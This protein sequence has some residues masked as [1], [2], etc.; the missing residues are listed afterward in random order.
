MSTDPSGIQWD[1]GSPAVG[2]RTLTRDDIGVVFQ[3]IVDVTNGR[4]FAHEALVRCKRPEYCSPPVLFEHAVR[5]GQCGPLGRLIRDVA[6]ATCGSAPLFVNVHPSELTSK[7]LVQADEP[8]G[9]HTAPVFVEVTE[10]AAMLHFDLCLG[11]IRELAKRSGAQLVIDDFGVGYSSLDR[12]AD[13][14][15]ALI[16][17]DMSLVKGIDKHKRRQVVV[18]HIVNMCSELEVLVVAE[19]I[20]TLDE[21]CCVRDLGVSY[22]QGF[23]LARPATPPPGHDWPMR[24]LLEPS[25]RHRPPRE[26]RRDPRAEPPSVPALHAW[27]DS[28]PA[29][30]VPAGGAVSS[31]AGRRPRG[32][33]SAEMTEMNG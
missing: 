27:C 20:E 22:L 24:A 19:G 32:E 8:I 21:L 7:W 28:T 14:E 29:S 5:E 3:P 30:G 23:L 1:A 33:W 31:V 12:L 13:L 17:L 26:V 4:M 15:P 18:R 16:K 25:T 9:F 10:A 11:V 6:F 2:I